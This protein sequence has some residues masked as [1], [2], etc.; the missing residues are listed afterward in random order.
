MGQAAPVGVGVHVRHTLA[1]PRRPVRAARMPSNCLSICG[2]TPKAMTGTVADE[3]TDNAIELIGREHAGAAAA[4]ADVDDGP[5]QLAVAGETL[6]GRIQG[7]LQVAGAQRRAAVQRLDGRGH[8]RTV[9]GHEAFGQRGR[10][11]IEGHE[12]D[13]IVRRPASQAPIARWP[14]TWRDNRPSGWP[15]CSTRITTSRGHV[16][17]ATDGL[18]ANAKTWFRRPG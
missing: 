7:L 3:I 2:P 10:V 4:I 14:A 11:Q 17:A 9:G 16:S 5:R 1:P 18:R 8:L 13:A 12:L 15:P 6:H